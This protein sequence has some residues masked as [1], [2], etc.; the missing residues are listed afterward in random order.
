MK[1]N[2]DKRGVFGD[3]LCCG[4]TRSFRLAL[5]GAVAVSGFLLTSSH[6]AFAQTRAPTSDEVGPPERPTNRKLR[7]MNELRQQR[8]EDAQKEQWVDRGYGHYMSSSEINSRGAYY[9]EGGRA[10][11]NPG[12]NALGQNGSA[13]PSD[14][15]VAF[16]TVPNNR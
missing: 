2:G 5:I 10:T 6:S 15:G 1:Q 11:Y 13:F 8:R 7:R 9:S 14:G 3:P 12:G 16:P 4:G